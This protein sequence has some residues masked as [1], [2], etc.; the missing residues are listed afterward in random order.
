MTDPSKSDRFYQEEGEGDQRNPFSRDRDRI[1][2]SRS[3]RRLSGVTQVARTEESYLFHDRMSHS[4]KVAQVA[5]RL[6]EHL[7]EG[8]RSKLDS[9]LPDITETAALA[10]D[11]GHPP[12]G[13]AV[14]DKLNELMSEHGGFEG[15]P[16]SF[17]I[18]TELGS[19]RKQ[20][21]GLNLTRA[22]LNAIIKYPWKRGENG[23][24]N[25]WGYYETEREY[26]KFARELSENTEGKCLESQ[27]MDWADDLTYA[28]HDL[29]D[30]YRA[31]LIPLDRIIQGDTTERAD[32]ISHFFENT[33]V[34]AGE[35][36]A[37]EFIQQ[38][39]F[40]ADKELYTPFTGTEAE[41][42]AMNKLVSNLVEK[43]MGIGSDEVDIEIGSAG[44]ELSISNQYKYDVKL[45]KHL[46]KY[47]VIT[48]SSLMAQQ[49]GQRELVTE[50][51][52]IL[53]KQSTPSSEYAN[54]INSPFREKL[55][56]LDGKRSES[57]RA[58]HVCD[59]ICSMTEKQT[60]LL[61]ERLTG[62]NQGSLLNSIIK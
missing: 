20:Y 10:H 55:N 35:Y 18:V 50:L 45:L 13:H 43:Y 29:N 33:N 1:L 16:Q 61:Y 24:Y 46:V 5:R 2:Y 59:F 3:F 27:I 14:E 30:F 28:V 39:H 11:L 56:K 47:Y 42:V 8:Y 32:F 60:I 21:P 7:Q 34:P 4:M 57:E 48:N 52:N 49:H 19:H 9:K 26:F 25:K 53:M 58:R 37:E 6:A 51:F 17:R 36:D 40:L 22:S 12:F 62:S 15:N 41:N 31:G 54:I 38:L 44:P 23:N